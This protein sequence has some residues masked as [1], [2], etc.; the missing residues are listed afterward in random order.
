M[1]FAHMMRLEFLISQLKQLRH[2]IIEAR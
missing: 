1:H 2:G